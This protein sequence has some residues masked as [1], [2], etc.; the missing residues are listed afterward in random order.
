MQSRPTVLHGERAPCENVSCLARSYWLMLAS[1]N[2][3]DLD[4]AIFSYAITMASVLLWLAPMIL[5]RARMHAL[6]GSSC[7]A[8][9]HT[10]GGWTRHRHAFDEMFLRHVRLVLTHLMR[11]ELA[12][13]F[14]TLTN[15]LP[16]CV[17]PTAGRS[18]GE[19]RDSHVCRVH[20][21][22]RHATDHRLQEPSIEERGAF[23][24]SY[25]PL[26]ACAQG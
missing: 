16:S 12:A 20:V 1:H 7:P 22:V 8:S 5:Q 2:Q 10:T 14:T 9:L 13:A 26:D 6:V 17:I 24:Q 3:R 23:N 25:S 15:P 18:V 11:C 4:E 21:H 19:L